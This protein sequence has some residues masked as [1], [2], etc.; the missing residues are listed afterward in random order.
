MTK[1]MV[2]V[3]GVLKVI[4]YRIKML[5]LLNKIKSKLKMKRIFIIIYFV[6]LAITTLGQEIEISPKLGNVLY[7][8]DGEEVTHVSGSVTVLK[9]NKK[10]YYYVKY[11]YYRGYVPKKSFTLEQ[12]V[13]I[14]K[15]IPSS[16]E[17]IVNDVQ[18]ENN[19]NA[20]NKLPPILSITDISFSKDLL[21]A[22][23]IANLSV[24][25]KNSGPGAAHGV[26]VNLECNLDDIIYPQKVLF[27]VIDAKNGEENVT[28][29]IKGGF[30]LP[31]SEAIL[32]IEVVEPNFKIRI[33]GKQLRIPT[34]EFKKPELLLA[35]YAVVENQS[36]NPNNQIDINE[37]IDLKFAIQNIGQG[38]AENV[39]VEVENKQNGVM[40]LG[41]EKD[42]GMM[43]NNPEFIFI[44]PGKFEIVVYKYFVNSEFTDD[45]MEFKITTNERYGKFGFT[46]NKLF[47]INKELE[48]AGH[49][50]TIAVVD[51]EV[52]KEV[53]IEDIPDFVVDVDTYIPV[54]NVVKSNTY[55]LIIGNEDYR[56]KQRGL[57]SEQNVE[58]AANDALVFSQYCIKTLG[59][60][61]NQVRLLKNATAAEMN[62]TIAWLANLARIE[63]GKANLIFYYSGHGLPD[64]ET[65]E[66]YLVP[67]DVSGTDLDYAVKVNNIYSRLTEYPAQ[68][69]TVFLDACFSGGARNEGL[70]AMRGIRI[71]PRENI[72]TG[73][74]VVLSSSTGEE[75]S[76]AYNEKQHGFFTYFLLKKLQ[77]TKGEATLA[78]LS[79]YL[80]QSVTKA[81]ALEG[82]IQTPQVKV[83]P[84]LENS[85]ES[86]KLK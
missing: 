33:Q 82:K 14:N 28:I 75:S 73:N 45:E 62:Q 76:A 8:S 84:Q 70:L 17:S 11:F 52:K 50:R 77:E 53:V 37:M 61:S 2:K 80:R 79:D 63:N 56:S 12:Q 6:N 58:F 40:F 38:T 47:P 9:N 5:F 69:I 25:L 68:Q 21:N 78:E 18:L 65:K 36:A 24:T 48:E 32:K 1:L 31:T 66:A 34:S 16:L 72:I 3:F 26:Y 19:V 39:T 30:N 49:I 42:N 4:E 51:E 7:N 67:V 59:I 64:E 13:E 15:I 29:D 20:I 57:T 22:E 44:Q 41:V 46:E 55:A 23:E 83:S 54:I 27:P 81:S 35:Q 74:L 43:R 71:K 60:P 85:W 86:L 10:D